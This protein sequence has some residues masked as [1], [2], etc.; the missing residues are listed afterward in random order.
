MKKTSLAQSMIEY[1]IVFAVIVGA[2]IIVARG[3][4]PK[5]RDAYSGLAAGMEKKVYGQ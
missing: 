3:F 4:R 5:V 2:L 1:V